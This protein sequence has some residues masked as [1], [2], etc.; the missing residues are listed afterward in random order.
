M[1][2]CVLCGKASIKPFCRRDKFTIFRCSSCSVGF[3]WPQISKEKSAEIYDESYFESWG[4]REDKNLFQMKQRTFILRLKALERIIPPG[5]ILDVGCATGF[6]LEVAKMRGWDIYGIE[7]NPHAVRLARKQNG[8][9]IYQG[10]IEEAKLERSFFDAIAMSDV[11]E[12][13]VD[14]LASLQRA[15]AILKP[16]GLIAITTPNLNSI[17]AHLL[18]GKWPHFKVEHQFYFSP[19]SLSDLLERAGF[20]TLSVNPAPKALSLNYIYAQRETSKTPFLTPAAEFLHKILP[21]SLR[22]IP[23]YFLAGE[24]FAIAQK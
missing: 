8:S 15:N 6:F 2:R 17:T 19:H 9:R 21:N 20:K 7:I 5:K 1:D 16:G 14:P 18:G 3:I 23:V 10:S 4:I 22:K 11:L 12:H 24:M 13:M